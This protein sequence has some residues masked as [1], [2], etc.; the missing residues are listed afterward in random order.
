MRRLLTLCALLL[1]ICVSVSFA[2]SPTTLSKDP[3]GA[4]IG[5]RSLTIQQA[6]AIALQKNPQ[7]TV[8][9]LRAMQAHENRA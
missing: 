4:K 9:K 3:T 1:I 7:I 8:G 5:G 6:E 2:Q